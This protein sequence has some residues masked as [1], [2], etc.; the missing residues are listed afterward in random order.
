M[1]SEAHMSAVQAMDRRDQETLMEFRR[2]LTELEGQE[3]FGPAFHALRAEV[4]SYLLGRQLV[5]EYNAWQ[6]QLTVHN[7]TMGAAQTEEEQRALYKQQLR[8][9]GAVLRSFV[10]GPSEDGDT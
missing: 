8:E 5:E 10:E 2:R 4:S 7:K 3:P 1:R 9:L 6:R